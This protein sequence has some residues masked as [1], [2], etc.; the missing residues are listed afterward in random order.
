MYG[1]ID[2]NYIESLFLSLINIYMHGKKGER[3]KEK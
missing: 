2:L 3:E 1:T